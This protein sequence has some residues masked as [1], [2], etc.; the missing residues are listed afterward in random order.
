M[1]MMPTGEEP[2]KGFEGYFN[3]KQTQ[4]ERAGLEINCVTLSQ[5]APGEIAEL[6]ELRQRALDNYTATTGHEVTR[7][8]IR[9][10][11]ELAPQGSTP[12]DKLIF[13]AYESGVLVAYAHVLCGW[14]RANE[15][16]VEQLLLDPT[17]RLKGIGS[18]LIDSVEQ[19]ARTAEVRATSILSLPTRDGSSSFW[20]HLGYVDRTSEL[21]AELGGSVVTVMRK[22][23]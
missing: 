16:T 7:L 3:E 11:L 5:I 10:E 9:E 22:E 23:L 13:R 8:P 2:P 17:R 19:L 14:P 1:S 15:W 18:K 12:S 21:A 6:D 20:D 4:G